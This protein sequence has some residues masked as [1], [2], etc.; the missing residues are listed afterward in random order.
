MTWVAIRVSATEQ[1]LKI[2]YSVNYS[3]GDV[4]FKGKTLTILVCIGFGGG[5]VAGALGLGGGSIY[6]P[7]LLAL[8]VHPRVSGATGMFLVLFSTVNSC[9]MNYHNDFL[10]FEYACWISAFAL[11]GSILGMLVMD[12]VVKMTGKASIMVWVLLLVFVISTISTPIFG[13]FSLN[14]N[15]KGGHDIYAFS[16]LCIIHE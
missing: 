16:P 5:L 7:A 13:A 3:E 14:E 11:L 9:L 10:D 4:I 1:D 2:K 6:N 12:K 8:G 15:A